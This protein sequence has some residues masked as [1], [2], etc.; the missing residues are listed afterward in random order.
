MKALAAI[1]LFIGSMG[2]PADDAASSRVAADRARP[3]P[4]G[5]PADGPGG[6]AYSHAGI[7]ETVHGEGGQQFWITE[8]ARPSPKKAPLVIFLHGYSAMTP[9]SYRGWVDH[10]AKRG[11]IVVYPRYQET[12]LT[13]PADYFPNIVASVKEALAVLGKRGHA[14]PDLERVAVVG[15]SVG[16]VEAANFAG[17]AAAGNLPPPKAVMFVQPG[18]GIKRGI[19][20]V[21]LDDCK[22][23]RAETQLLFV[24]GADD[25]IV[26]AVCARRIWRDTKHVRDRSFVTMQSDDHGSPPLRADHLSPV[27]WTSEVTDALDWFGHWKMFDGLLTAAFSD[28]PFTVDPGMGAWSDGVPVKPLEVER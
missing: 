26:G 14:A 19:E 17:A 2:L 3:T 1:L 6:S 25:G 28:K 13:P 15:H 27:S 11:N 18:Q 24:V 23:I 8:P 20:F 16:G 5:Q 10:L 4:P 12:L 9:D 22:A 21:T 7:R